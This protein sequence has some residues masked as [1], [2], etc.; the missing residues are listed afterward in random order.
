LDF[1]LDLDLDFDFG[2]V[3]GFVFGLGL[4][5]RFTTDLTFSL[6]G[7]ILAYFIATKSTKNFIAAKSI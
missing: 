5:E 6:L 4:L 2:F 3:F 7:G 1:D